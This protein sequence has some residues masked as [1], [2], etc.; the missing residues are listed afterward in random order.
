MI[1]I[2]TMATHVPKMAEVYATISLIVHE[3][4]SMDG[5]IIILEFGIIP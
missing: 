3:P 5:V 4:K 2:V 1:K